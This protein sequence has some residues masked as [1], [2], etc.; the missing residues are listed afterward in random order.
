MKN[1]KKLLMGA[2]GVLV[3][4]TL[5]SGCGSDNRD[6][7]K[8]MSKK[9]LRVGTE[10][11]YPPFEFT[12]DNSDALQGFDIEIMEA[13]AK[14]MG[15]TVE[16]HNIGF[17]ALIPAITSDQL[18]VAISGMSITEERKKIVNFTDAYLLSC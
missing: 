10:A 12:K 16:W 14:R 5:I 9:V 11:A 1:I 15:Y 17:D 13:L 2:L 8:D 7:S 18:D 3:V 6:M 4:A